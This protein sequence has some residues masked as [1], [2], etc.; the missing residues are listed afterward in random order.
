M[1]LR[2]FSGLQMTDVGLEERVT[3]QKENDG[4]PQNGKLRPFPR[5]I[6]LC[7]SISPADY[8]EIFKYVCTVQLRPHLDMECK[9]K[10]KQECIP[11][12]CIPS[13]AMAARMGCIPVCTGQGGCL[14]RARLPRGVYPEG[15]SQG[16]V[17]PGGVCPGGVSAWGLSAKG[18]YLPHTLL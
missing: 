7:D 8:S 15:Y 6:N 17:C 11:V 5:S 4:N 18:R 3:A 13:A 16:G 1:Y 2:P 14:P 10:S 12:G 9:P